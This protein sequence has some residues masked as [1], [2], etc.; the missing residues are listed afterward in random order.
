MLIEQVAGRIVIGFADG[1]AGQIAQIKEKV[2]K[3]IKFPVLEK[4][5]KFTT[6]PNHTKSCQ[7]G[8]KFL[9]F[10]GFIKLKIT[11]MRKIKVKKIKSTE[12]ILRSVALQE[13]FFFIW[14]LDILLCPFFIIAL[15]N[16]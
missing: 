12:E 16:T 7:K 15:L 5:N 8:N 4:F 13:I 6:N 1:I 11:Y 14:A 9:P 3:K 2:W 10:R